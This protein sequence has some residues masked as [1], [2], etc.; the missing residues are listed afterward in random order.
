M[1]DK[2]ELHLHV[3]IITCKCNFNR[4]I[5]QSFYLPYSQVIAAANSQAIEVVERNRPKGTN[6]LAFRIITLYI[7]PP[8]NVILEDN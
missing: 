3:M 8:Q 6:R 2:K 5:V 1:Q 4:T 7:M